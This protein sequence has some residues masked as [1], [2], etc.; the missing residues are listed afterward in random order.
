MSQNRSG[1]LHVLFAGC[2]KKLLLYQSPCLSLSASLR[3]PGGLGLDVMFYC[4][5]PVFLT[6]PWASL[7]WGWMEE[8]AVFHREKSI[9]LNLC[10]TMLNIPMGRMCR[11]MCLYVFFLASEWHINSPLLSD[12][13]AQIHLLDFIPTRISSSLAQTRAHRTSHLHNRETVSALDV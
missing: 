3:V 5:T 13:S 8:F 1:P 9:K 10:R 6:P 7:H 11:C 2:E 12:L 4:C